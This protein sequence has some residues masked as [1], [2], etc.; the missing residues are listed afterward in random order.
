MLVAPHALTAPKAT[1]VYC[2][3]RCLRLRQI[4]FA[5]PLLPHC[6][7]ESQRR[8]SRRTHLSKYNKDGACLRR[9]KPPG[10][11]IEPF[12]LEPNMRLQGFVVQC[13]S[14]VQLPVPPVHILYCLQ[15]ILQKARELCSQ[16][17]CRVCLFLRTGVGR[18]SRL[19]MKL[20]ESLVSASRLEKCYGLPSQSKLCFFEND[21]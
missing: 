11:E 7:D 3:C 20:I 10:A 21:R 2:A 19:S 8:S 12:K 18:D 13:V 5:A 6:S 14:P 9:A 17:W 1:L 4:S 16:A 15:N